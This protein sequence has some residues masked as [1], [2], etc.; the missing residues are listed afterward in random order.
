MTP[1]H[2]PARITASQLRTVRR[3]LAAG[4]TL[5][6]AALAIGVMSQTLDLAL[7]ELCGDLRE[8]IEMYAPRP[9]PAA[10]FDT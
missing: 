8:W 6:Q 10:M 2:D 3:L 4:A 1:Y 5:K 9:R 7:W